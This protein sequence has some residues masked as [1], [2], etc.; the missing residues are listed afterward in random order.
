MIL[1]QKI[2]LT[3]L[4]SCSSSCILCPSGCISCPVLHGARPARE[5]LY[6]RWQHGSWFQ[7]NTRGRRMW[8]PTIASLERKCEEGNVLLLDTRAAWKMSKT[9]QRQRLAAIMKC[10]G[11]V[12]LSLGH[13]SPCTI[14][15]FTHTSATQY[16]HNKSMIMIVVERAQFRFIE[17]NVVIGWSMARMQLMIVFSLAKRC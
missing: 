6:R 9:R 3:E 12:H 7:S 17:T 8:G 1:S 13:T 10:N 4:S 15:W 11:V 16:S 2:Q 14:W 5:W